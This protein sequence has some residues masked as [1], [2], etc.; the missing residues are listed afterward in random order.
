VFNHIFDFNFHG[1]GHGASISS[2]RALK[3]DN[4]QYWNTVVNTDVGSWPS[5]LH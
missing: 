2:K 1:Q 4:T 5:Q 3:T